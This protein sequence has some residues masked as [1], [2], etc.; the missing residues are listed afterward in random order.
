MTLRIQNVSLEEIKN[1][2][3]EDAGERGVLIQI[4]DCGGSFPTPKVKFDKVFQFDFYDVDVVH[5]EG[6]PKPYHGEAIVDILKMALEERRNVVVHCHA[7]LCRSGAVAE[8]GVMIGFTDTNKLRLP[9]VLL[10]KHMMTALGWTY[11]VESDK[12]ELWYEVDSV[13]RPTDYF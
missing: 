11:D 9:N 7:G 3:H 8:V 10:K 13:Y 2:Q 1:G 12:K 4:T 6:G 5:I